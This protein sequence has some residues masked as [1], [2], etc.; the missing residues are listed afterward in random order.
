MTPD[1]DQV[2]VVVDRRERELRLKELKPGTSQYVTTKKYPVA[3]GLAGYATEPGYYEVGVKAKD[4]EWQV[5]NSAWA[6]QAGL[7]P[8][9]VIAGGAPNNPIRDRWM[10]FNSEHG[11]GIHGTFA[12]ESIG[13]RASHGCI[14]M[15]PK[16]VIDLYGRVPKGSIVHID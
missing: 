15:L 6:T 10:E 8:G 12:E 11:E 5:P 13:T 16:D 9:T 14:R 1:Q 2:I 7:K 4:P 3:I